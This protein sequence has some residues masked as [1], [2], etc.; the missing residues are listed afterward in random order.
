MKK[1]VNTKYGIPKSP[2]EKCKVLK[3]LSLNVNGLDSK[4]NL[5]IV[6]V[7]ASNFDIVLFSETFNDKPNLKNSF[8]ENYVP[9]SKQKKNEN[10]P[11]KYGGVHGISFLIKSEF[12]QFIDIIEQ[13]E[14]DNVLWLKINKGFVGY[15]IILGGVYIPCESSKFYKYFENQIFDKIQNDLIH[16]KG[17]YVNAKFCLLGDFNS[18][19]GLLNDFLEI[20]NE[21]AEATEYSYSKDVNMKCIVE[22]MGFPTNR[23]NVDKKVNNNGRRM[24]EICQMSDLKIVN[25]RFFND[26]YVGMHTC[27]NKNGGNSVVDYFVTSYSLFP[28]ISEFNIEAFDKCMSDVHHPVS[29][30]LNFQQHVESGNELVKEVVEQVQ[31]FVQP[32]FLCDSDKVSKMQNLFLDVDV[33]GLRHQLEDFQADICQEKL[34]NVCKVLSETLVSKA[35]DADIYKS[36]KPKNNNSGG[37]S[38]PWFD[39]ECFLQRKQYL[40]I[41]NRLKRKHDAESV[42]KMRLEAAKYKKALKQKTKA[43]YKNLSK[44][45]RNLKSNNA[46]QYWD[47]I[48]KSDE[49]QKYMADLSMKTFCEHFKKLSNDDSCEDTEKVYPNIQPNDNLELNN[50]FTKEEV[51][52]VIKKLKNN[53]ACG[54]DLI[55]N[56]MLKCCSAELLDFMVDLFNLI[57]DNGMVP[58]EWCIGVIVPLYKN[59]KG[60]LKDPDN[61][62]GITLLSCIGKLFT[63]LINNR[64]VGYLDRI[65]ALGDEQAGFRDG[66]STI[67]HIFVLNSVIN[68]YLSKQKR[69]Y[70]AFIDYKKAF[71]LVDRSN[72]WCKLI[73]EG[74]SGK[75]LQVIMNMYKK[76]KSCVMMNGKISDFF[77][78]N[79]GVRQGENLS[80]ILFA[81]F[82]NDFE[83]FLSR[84]YSGLSD[85]SK[86]INSELGDDDVELFFK[87]F[88]L[89]YA[90]DTIVM[91]ESEPELQAALNAVKE[92]C[93]LWK[94][95]VNLKKTKVLIFSRGKIKK[96][97]K[98]YFGVGQLDVDFSYTYLGMLINYNGKLNKAIAKQVNQAR[99]ASFNL[100]TKVRNLRL[101][102][103]MHIDL[104]DKVVI[105]VLLYGSEVWGYEDLEHIEVFYRKFLKRISHMKSYT[106]NCMVY[107]E[108][109][110]MEIKRLVYSRMC[111]FWCRILNGSSHKLSFIIY[112]L[113]RSLHYNEN[114][115]FRS[116]WIAKMESI[117]DNTG[118]SHIWRNEMRGLHSTYVTNLLKGKLSD[119]AKQNLRADIDSNS[120]CDNYRIF[121]NDLDFE[122]YFLNLNFN[123]RKV[124]CNFRCRNHSLPITLNRFD[125]DKDARKHLTLCNKCDSG[126]TGDEVHYLCKCSF[127]SEERKKLLGRNRFRNPNI[128][129][130][131]SIM[132][133]KSRS[134]RTNLVTFLR[135]VMSVF[136]VD[137][138]EHN[139][140]FANFNYVYQ[141]V[142]TRSGRNVKRP[143]RLDL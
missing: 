62:R 28:A 9:F 132:S 24:I 110:T 60:N 124:I 15:E 107:A 142:I 127:F 72:L 89:L 36:K 53:K 115:D 55:R 10:D 96:I 119:I 128:F 50:L 92:Y 136:D 20:E 78:C 57:L 47:I 51:V 95:T 126:E 116:S 5:G 22:D 129:T 137:Y 33:E 77:K 2:T 34:D 104:F 6:D 86:D 37:K 73:S 43:Y 140:V 102:A 100:S 138:D 49:G 67:D 133:C 75:I 91:A 87:L 54:L 61:Y 48:N 58:T 125:K 111:N 3:L 74:I 88:V 76:A 31:S 123:D 117:F 69:L 112:K 97:P 109:G 23:Y 113:T 30:E 118:L 93:D 17:K 121:K 134:R 83:Y 41:K 103:D 80:P 101:P 39:K 143:T 98:F 4:L 35:F 108:T 105:P 26:K 135:T 44:K 21:V 120:Q 114:I 131:R 14:S 84:K 18:R 1:A 8:L 19:T 11:F 141:P 71:D 139:N 79:V 25:G 70:C 46:K 27:R 7:H 45:L 65:G 81:I 16:L 52:K 13:V 99:K 59:N 29:L 68:I 64:I 63:A 94:L 130:V 85:I 42:V 122:D 12:S 66:F 32:T 90:D 40:R 106:P 56:E 82:L 38:K